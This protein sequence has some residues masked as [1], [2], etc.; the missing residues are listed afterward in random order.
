MHGRS[1]QVIGLWT[2]KDLLFTFKLGEGCAHV[3]EL[4]FALEN[5]VDAKADDLSC[6]SRPCEW[7]L[8]WNVFNF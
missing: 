6:T 7:S 2:R 3:A 8:H 5:T 4:L 1:I